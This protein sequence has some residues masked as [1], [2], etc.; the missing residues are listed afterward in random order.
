V[1][2]ANDDFFAPKENLIKASAPEW[3]E[4]EYTDQGKWMDGWETRRRRTPGHDWAIVQLGVPG[5]VRG[6]VIDTSFFTGNYPEEATI[7]A[8]AVD[9][10]PSGEHMMSDEVQWWPLLGKSQLKGNTV[11]V[12]PI[13]GSPSERRV[14]HLRLNIFPD[15][16]VARL[17]V[18]GEVVPDE[19]IFTALREI[20]LASLR[21]GGLVVACS[22]MHYGNPQNLILPGRSTHMGDGWETR[23]RRGPGNDWA[24]VRLA[25]RGIVERIELDTDHFKGNAPGNCMIEC[26]DVDDKRGRFDSDQAEWKELLPQ[27]ALEP[28]AQHHWEG[29]VAKPATHVRLNIYPDGGVARLRLF[30]RALPTG[31]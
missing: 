20:D 18:H 4:G 27:T 6:V 8:A 13:A 1:L 5:I 15:G 17:R 31:V 12:F 24:I 28:D 11:N 10:F 16:G 22:D 7:D 2:A 30:G 14:T 26:C 25:R 23:R 29:I 19:E 21:N 9:G 3:R